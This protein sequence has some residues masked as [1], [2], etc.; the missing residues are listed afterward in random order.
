MFE[1]LLAKSAKDMSK[2]ETIMEHTNRLLSE[3]ETL[4]LLY[5][6]ILTETEWEILRDACYYHDIGK[7]NTK[8]QNKI[9]SLKERIEDELKDLEEVPHAYLS[10]A[11]MPIRKL[12]KKY[13]E[14]EL[15]C[16]L[17]AVYYHHERKEEQYEVSEIIIEKDL[18][19]YVEALKK[20]DLIFLN[21]QNKIILVMLIEKIF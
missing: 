1:R 5:P 19:K 13:S 20:K 21:H 11:Y 8:F 12:K 6:N 10:C 15:K 18:P 4:K 7:A 17:M 3:Y 2:A 14:E 9:R 16:L